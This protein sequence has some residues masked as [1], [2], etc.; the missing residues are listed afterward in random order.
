MARRSIF[1]RT[2]LGGSYMRW[3]W[4]FLPWPRRIPSAL[5]PAPPLPETFAQWMVRP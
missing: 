1:K 3:P 4:D 5:Y 2:C